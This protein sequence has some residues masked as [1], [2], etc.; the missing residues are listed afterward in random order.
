MAQD[1]RFT[2][3]PDEAMILVYKSKAP[4]QRLEIAFSL[5]TFARSLVKS[6]LKAQHPDW[7]EKRIEEETSLRMLHAAD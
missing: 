3:L 7:P 6:G 4:H 5:W 1:I 2:D